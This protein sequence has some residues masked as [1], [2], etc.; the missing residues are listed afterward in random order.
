LN[1]SKGWSSHYSDHEVVEFRI[2]GDRRIIATKTTIPDMG[3]AALIL[4]RG[5][6]SEVPMETTFES[7]GVTF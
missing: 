6:L 5:L 4:L 3:R 2:F 1:V 7:F